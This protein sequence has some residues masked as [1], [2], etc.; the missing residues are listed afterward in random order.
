MIIGINASKA[1]FVKKTG[2]EKTVFELIKNLKTIDTKNTYWLYTNNKLPKEL[3]SP[4]FIE[5]CIPFP[6]LWHKKR[7]PLSLLFNKPDVF[8]EISAELPYFSP[9]NSIVFVHDLASKH[10]PEAYT[11]KQRLLLNNAFSRSQKADKLVFTS[12]ST[13]EDYHKFYNIENQSFVVP[14]AF[15]PQKVLEN[16]KYD[17]EYFLFVGRIE[18]R[19]NLRRLIKSYISF[20]DSFPDGPKLILAG[21]PG[22]GYKDI[23]DEINSSPQKVKED[24]LLTGY[25]SDQDL[26]SL[27][28]NATAFVFPS[29][30]EGFGIPILESMYYRTPVITSKTSSMP[31][32]TGE[33][34]ILVNPESESDIKTALEKVYSDKKLR[35]DLISKGVENVKKYSWQASAEKLYNLIKSYE[36]SN[37]S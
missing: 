20:R 1:S 35:N 34:A 15:T 30:Y 10:F 22:Y 2:I 31:E 21:S 25:I 26:P 9:K 24:I 17:H 37:R 12:K 29:L 28:Q 6:F 16:K 3:L 33:A 4:N 18:A 32:V 36:N 19:K 5:K 14:L 8:I 13:K 27:Y 7:L 11:L 23:M